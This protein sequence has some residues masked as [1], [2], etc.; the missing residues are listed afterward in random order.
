MHVNDPNYEEDERETNSQ[1]YLTHIV[2][3]GGFSLSVHQSLVIDEAF[4]L[5]E[6]FDSD[7]DPDTQFGGEFMGN[8]HADINQFYN[9]SV[10]ARNS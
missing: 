2:D 9:D 3:L 1:L 4:L 7:R 10:S 5:E 8:Q 6:I